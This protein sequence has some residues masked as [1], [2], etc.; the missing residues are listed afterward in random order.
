MG[1]GWIWRFLDVRRVLL[2]VG[3]ELILSEE[4]RISVR[5][6]VLE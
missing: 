2:G 3:V 4:V 5:V 6:L 1:L